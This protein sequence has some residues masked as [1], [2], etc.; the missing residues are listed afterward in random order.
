M[1]KNSAYYASIILYTFRHLSYAQD[2]AS[3][4]GGSLVVFYK[5]DTIKHTYSLTMLW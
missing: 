1:H 5:M 3:I 2:Y 4:I